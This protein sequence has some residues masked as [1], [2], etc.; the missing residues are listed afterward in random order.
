MEPARQANRIE[1]FLLPSNAQAPDVAPEAV[2]SASPEKAP[3]LASPIVLLLLG[4][5][6]EGRFGIEAFRIS[7]TLVN[8]TAIRQH[9]S[10]EDDTLM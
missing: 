2:L 10:E 1:G 9:S 7:T 8:G 6:I 5:H 4:I 3:P